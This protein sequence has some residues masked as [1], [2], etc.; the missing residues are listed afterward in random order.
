MNAATTLGVV[1]T[2]WRAEFFVK[3]AGLLSDQLTLVGA[4]T[5]RPETAEQVAQRWGVPC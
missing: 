2:D 3:L 1:G 5:R 4:A